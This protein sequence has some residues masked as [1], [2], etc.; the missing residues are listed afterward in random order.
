MRIGIFGG[1]FDPPHVGHLLAATDATEALALDRL[2]FVPAAQQPLKV[3]T[4]AAPAGERLAMLRLLASGN[5]RWVVDETEIERGGLSYTVDTLRE[6]RKQWHDDR[7]LE[8]FLLLGA[9]AAAL[10]PQWRAFAEVAE[11]AKIVV[12]SRGEAQERDAMGAAAGRVI[13][14]RRVDVSSTEIRDRV[15]AE[16]SI[17]GFV[18][19]EIA[20]YIARGRLYR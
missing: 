18:P 3:G 9:D 10:L 8:L 7:A 19:D 5:P 16:K 14:T 4:S 6:L 17:R 2:L 15:R 11:M 12:L 20:E 13:A 1:T